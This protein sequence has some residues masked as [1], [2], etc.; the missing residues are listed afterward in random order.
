MR[1]LKLFTVCILNILFFFSL[2]LHAKPNSIETNEIISSDSPVW[3]NTRRINQVVDKIQKVMEW[4]IRKVTV[5]WYSDQ[6]QFKAVHGFDGSVLAVSRKP[7]NSIHVGPRVNSENFD[8]VF[9]HELVHI[10]LFQKYKEA[11]PKWLEEGFANYLSKTDQK[12]WKVNYQFLSS[13]SLP[14]DIRTLVHPF[15]GDAELSDPKFHYQASTALI[16]MIASKCN[17][18]DLIQLS[19]GK[20]L[21]SYLPTFCEIKDINQEFR[22]W[23]KKKSI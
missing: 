10:I 12:D 6:N 1:N 4:D 23:I 5:Y 7:D 19:V 3:L 9:G 8:R 22:A 16:E 2:N 14:S 21:E 18:R 17:L 20:S 15:K 11:I 13:H